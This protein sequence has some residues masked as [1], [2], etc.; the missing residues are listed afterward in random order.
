MA[1]A[2]RAADGTRAETEARLG[3]ATEK[4]KR[5]LPKGQIGGWLA[6]AAIMAKGFGWTGFWEGGSR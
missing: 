6:L 4:V 1:G 2:R 3:T 5:D